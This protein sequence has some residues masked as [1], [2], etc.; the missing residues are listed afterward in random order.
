M[1]PAIPAN[2]I[3]IPETQ[4]QF[5]HTPNTPPS[6]P[7]IKTKLSITDLAQVGK[8]SE[9]IKLALEE[10]GDPKKNS[11]HTPIYRRNTSYA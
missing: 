11:I 10:A 9:A 1:N 7:T 4:K 3:S 6:I 2:I 8:I 5:S